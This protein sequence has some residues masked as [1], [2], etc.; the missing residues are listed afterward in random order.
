MSKN[1][2]GNFNVE[3]YL[4]DPNNH[5]PHS[6]IRQ[7]VSQRRGSQ[8]TALSRRHHS[9]DH[10]KEIPSHTMHEQREKESYWRTQEGIRNAARENQEENCPVLV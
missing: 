2:N 10:D 5:V 1:N 3:K 6:Q 8:K 7:V 9:H 4:E